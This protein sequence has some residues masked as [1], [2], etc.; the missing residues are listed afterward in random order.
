MAGLFPGYTGARQV[1]DVELE[2]V[3]TSCGY[4]VPYYDLVG[5]RPTLDKWA[6]NHGREGIEAYWQEKNTRSLDGK[7]TGIF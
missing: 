1:F 5:E 6:E 3:Q 2:L 7:D 4:A